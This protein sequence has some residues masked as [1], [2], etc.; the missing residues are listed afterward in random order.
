MP[1]LF[2]SL[3]FVPGNNPR[4]LAK[5]RNLAVD[6]ICLDLEDSVPAAQKAEARNMITE[7]LRKGGYH[8]AVFVRVNS[9][10]SGTI[11]QDLGAILQ[12]RPDGIV[13]PKVN[14]TEEMDAIF[15]VLDR[16]ERD[17]TL[18]MPSIESAAGVLNAHSIASHGPR[19]CGLVFGIFDLLN[20]MGME[21]SKDPGTALYSRSKIPVDAAAAGVPAIDCIWQDTDDMVGFE[22]DCRLGRSMGYSGKSIIHPDQVDMAHKTFVPTEAEIRWARRVQD[23]YQGASSSGKGA[24]LLDGKMIDEAHYKR[25]IAL[26]DAT[27]R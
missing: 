24:T 11:P 2:R 3:I 15:G 13:I 5:A 7:S 10:E 14:N 12:S 16:V 27:Y 23:M 25:A 4:F 19:V 8:G 22:A 26:L 6:I 1:D 17:T 21:Y 18:V 20:D 9:P